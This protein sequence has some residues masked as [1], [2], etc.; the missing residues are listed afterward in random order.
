MLLL[1]ATTHNNI[2]LNKDTINSNNNSLLTLPFHPIS[3][4]KEDINTP[5][6][7]TPTTPKMGTTIKNPL[8]CMGLILWGIPRTIREVTTIKLVLTTLQLPLS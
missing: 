3:S 5:T 1:T 8:L 6:I 4:S 2:S 7:T